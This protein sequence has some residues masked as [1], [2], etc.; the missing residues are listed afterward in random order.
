ML[1]LAGSG[2]LR[3]QTARDLA[4]AVDQTIATERS[5]Q[6]R[7]D[8]W[9]G[10]RAELGNRYRIAK[11]NVEWLQQRLTVERERA[12]ALDDRVR[13][14]RRRLDES[15]R[16]QAVIQDSL[17]AVLHRLDRVVA[18]DLPFL[19]EERET[20]LRHLR[21]ELARPEVD[22]AEKLRRLLEALLIEAQYGQTVEVTPERITL[23]GREM[24]V[25]VLRLGRLAVFWRTPDGAQVGT[26]D[27]VT[28]A[29]VAL[30]DRYARDLKKAMEMA[31]RMRPVQL[32]SLPLG[33]IA[34]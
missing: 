10:E 13:E 25:D 9:A 1:V 7:K 21:G 24:F 18:A 30:A 16:L 2:S 34:S 22:A 14:L 33:R 31:T 19:V 15:T 3:A 27:P 23:D 6:E 20:R 4:G 29:H 17:V 32:L 28:G 26:W 12:A 8:D 11:S 5:M